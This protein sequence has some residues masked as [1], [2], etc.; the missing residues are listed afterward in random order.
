[1]TFFTPSLFFIRVALFSLSSSEAL[2]FD[3]FNYLRFIFYGY[4][5]IGAASSLDKSRFGLFLL[6]SSL[7]VSETF[8]VATPFFFF[9]FLALLSILSTSD[10]AFYNF[11]IGTV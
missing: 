4:S 6:S 3:E 2:D 10:S 5:V 7:S 9:F 11:I 8:P 1:L